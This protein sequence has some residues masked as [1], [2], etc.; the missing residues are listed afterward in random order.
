MTP[1][2]TESRPLDLSDLREADTLGRAWDAW[3]HDDLEPTRHAISQGLPPGLAATVED[4]YDRDDTL[5]PSAAF[6]RGMRRDLLHLHDALRLGA[7]AGVEPALA[8]PAVPPALVSVSS[9]PVAIRPGGR[10][11]RP[12]RPARRWWPALEFAAAMIVV[13]ALFG[14]TFG[15]A[16]IAEFFRD[17][18]SGN[19]ASNGDGSSRPVSLA[20]G[21]TAAI[22]DTYEVGLRP[23]HIVVADGFVAVVSGEPLSRMITL[24]VFNAADGVRIWTADVNNGDLEGAQGRDSAPVIADGKLYFLNRAAFLY[25]IDIETYD[26]PGSLLVSQPLP[27]SGPASDLVVLDGIVYAVGSDFEGEG[28][29]LPDL[30]EQDGQ[31]FIAGGMADRLVGVD[32]ATGAITMLVDAF[33]GEVGVWQFDPGSASVTNAWHATGLVATNVA[34]L[35]EDRVVVTSVS[36][37][38]MSNV[39][40]IRDADDLQK[41]LGSFKSDQGLHGEGNVVGETVVLTVSDPASSVAM[42]VLDPADFA[43]RTRLPWDDTDV[44]NKPDPVIAG[45]STVVVGDDDV[46]RVFDPATGAVLGQTTIGTAG[47]VAAM[48]VV[49]DVIV[50]AF[51]DGTIAS[52][53]QVPA[54]APPVPGL[55]STPDPA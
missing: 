23:E 44:R 7:A 2:P 48:T 4:I 29:N 38:G 26:D 42:Y 49:D 52:F 34:A 32:P 1:D 17:A 43:E 25:V 9:P 46:L 12:S 20:T 19:F 3:L 30:T 54:D 27:F 8:P 37:D 33:P 22:R 50:V 24:S 47:E 40:S 41:E 51:E 21:W 45:E 55:A 14:V 11:R 39:V 16:R 28:P 13:A 15:N 31:L 35:G 18:R 53:T 5:G 36:S 10:R 6:R